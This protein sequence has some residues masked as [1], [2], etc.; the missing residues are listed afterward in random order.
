MDTTFQLMVVNVLPFGVVVVLVTKW[1]CS[2]L[3]Y[4][5]YKA[6]IYDYSGSQGVRKRKADQ[7]Y[8]RGPEIVFIQIPDMLR[9]APMFQ[10]IKHWRKFGGAPP[11]GLAGAAV[12]Q[13]A[14][15]LRKAQQ[16]RNMGGGRGGP[17]GRGGGIGGRG[18]VFGRGGPVSAPG[19]YGPR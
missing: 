11:E 3:F 14:A 1:P 9:H 7:V 10:R 15:I 8:L 12:G 13:A 19:Q 4:K 17:V 2:Q 6:V 18:G 16:R 5:I